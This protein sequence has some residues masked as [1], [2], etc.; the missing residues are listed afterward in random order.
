MCAVCAVLCWINNFSVQYILVSLYI[1]L[2]RYSVIYGIK[3]HQH[4]KTQYITLLVHLV[5]YNLIL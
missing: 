2:A 3:I 1:G 5:F 4:C